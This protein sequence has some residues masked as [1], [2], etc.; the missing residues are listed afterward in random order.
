LSVVFSF[1]S[2]VE[3]LVVVV[4]SSTV[5]DLRGLIQIINKKI[6]KF[7]NN[8]CLVKSKS[9]FNH[10]TE[11][12]AGYNPLFQCVDISSI[13]SCLTCMLLI[14]KLLLLLLLLI[15]FHWLQ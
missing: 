6:N 13:L 15:K 9:V 1:L 3:G 5:M 2:S 10:D 7:V 8:C 4:V 11:V 14:N 12:C